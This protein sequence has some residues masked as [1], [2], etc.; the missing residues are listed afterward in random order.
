M[1]TNV[2]SWDPSLGGV[3]TDWFVERSYISAISEVVIDPSKECE[4]ATENEMEESRMD[5]DS[6]EKVTWAT[7]PPKDGD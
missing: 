4:G 5:V 7:S 3:D 2:T 1:N 6:S